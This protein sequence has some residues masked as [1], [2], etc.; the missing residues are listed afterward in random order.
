MGIQVSDIH[1]NWNGKEY[2]VKATVYQKEHIVLPNRKVLRPISWWRG[3]TAPRIMELVEVVH[4]LEHAPVGEIAE[5]VG[6][7]I[8]A[9]EVE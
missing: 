2:A 7:A 9:H 6:N 3:A 4:H 1:F 5:H 8:L